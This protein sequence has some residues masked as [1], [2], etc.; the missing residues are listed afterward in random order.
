MQG[1]TAFIWLAVAAINP[2]FADPSKTSD[3]LGAKYVG[4]YVDSPNR[5]LAASSTSSGDMTIESCHTYCNNQGYSLFGVQYAEQCF[6]DN[7]INNNDTN[8]PGD[9]CNYACT[10]M[11]SERLTESH[12][13]LQKS[14]VMQCAL[15]TAIPSIISGH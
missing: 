5:A 6:C 15:V 4:C 3:D 1:R 12:Y 13:V 10:G 14:D 8:V 11:Y 2:A 7:T 9:G